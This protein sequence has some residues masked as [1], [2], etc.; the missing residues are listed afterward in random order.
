MFKQEMEQDRLWRKDNE[1][2]I[3]ANYNKW[4]LLLQFDPQNSKNV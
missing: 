4:L 2:T 1:E 3:K